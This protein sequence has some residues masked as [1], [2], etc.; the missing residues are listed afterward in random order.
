MS[1][2]KI[3]RLFFTPKSVGMFFSYCC[4]LSFLFKRNL[5]TYEINTLQH[6]KCF[7]RFLFTRCFLS[8]TT[9]HVNKN[10]THTFSMK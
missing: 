7:V 1:E 6:G 8:D 3:V 10:R 5:S 2:P 4:Q 9:Q